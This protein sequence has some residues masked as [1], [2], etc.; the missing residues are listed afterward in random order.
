MRSLYFPNALS[1]CAIQ[2]NVAVFRFLLSLNYGYYLA[3]Q[4][5]NEASECANRGP[6]TRSET[7]IGR[8]H[9]SETN[10]GMIQYSKIACGFIK[11]FLQF[12]LFDR[13]ILKVGRTNIILCNSN[14]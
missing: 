1:R 10:D 9:W 6:V 14:C 3:M 5:S 12:N 13:F 8:K 2:Q 11:M 7:V 4:S